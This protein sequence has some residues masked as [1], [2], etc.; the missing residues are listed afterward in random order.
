M[1]PHSFIPALFGHATNDTFIKIAH[2]ERLHAAYAGDKN[3][4]RYVDCTIVPC[5][6]HSSCLCF[7]CG[8]VT[9][10]CFLVLHPVLAGLRVITTAGGQISSMHLCLYSST[11]RCRLARAQIANR[12]G[13]VTEM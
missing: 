6:L 1:V 5:V 3:L 10:H 8:V 11:T 12:R 9:A 13:R 2:S 7:A 4:I